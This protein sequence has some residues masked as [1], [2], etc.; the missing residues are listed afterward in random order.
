LTSLPRN[1][2]NWI[3]FSRLVLA[4]LLFVFLGLVGHAHSA[5]GGDPGAVVTWV[6]DYESLLLTICTV[7]FFLAGV[8]DFL[9]GY[10]ARRWDLQTDFGR[11]VDPFADKVIVCGAFVLL[12][13]VK[14][15][16]VA[17]WMVVVILA[18]ELL[19]DGL[20]G[21][22]E[23]RGVAFPSLWA[24]KVKMTVQSL[25]IVWVLLTLAAFPTTAW[26]NTL[27]SVLV[28]AAVISTIYSGG[29]YLYHARGV[30]GSDQIS[31]KDTSAKDMAAA[32]LTAQD[33]VVQDPEGLDPET[34]PPK[35][36]ESTSHEPAPQEMAGGAP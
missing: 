2:P 26:A 22:A 28:V 18:R 31:V 9:D 33:L 12:I 27:G 8:S 30:L 21:F 6:R 24:G 3:T 14:G 34:L 13:P 10:V 32:A 25:A 29:I 23:S 19:V 17:P 36:R 5:T 4:A 1:L 35:T 16:H 7:I 11:I 15:S 20:R